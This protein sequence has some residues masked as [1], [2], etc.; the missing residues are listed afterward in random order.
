MKDI[1]IYTFSTTFD[2]FAIISC[3]KTF[4]F[5]TRIDKDLA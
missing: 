4:L 3:K 1:N 5:E 2:N